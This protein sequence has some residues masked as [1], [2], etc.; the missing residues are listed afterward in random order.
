MKIIARIRGG[1]GNQLFCYA[2]AR[3]LAVLNNAELVID[4]VT[5]FV[6]DQLY[7]RNYMLNR[8]QISAR[9]ATPSERMEPF[10]RYRRGVAKW[11]ARRV[12]FEQRRYIEQESLDFDERLLRIS[13]KGTIY[14]DGLWENESYFKDAEQI[15]REDL[16]VI[17]PTDDMNK[18]IAAEIHEKSAVAIHV[19]WFSAP[20]SS[21]SHHIST[22]Y[23]RD[24]LNL[25]ENTVGKPHYFLFSDNLDAARTMLSLPE[26][27]VTFMS[28]NRGSDNAYADLWLMTQCKHIIIANSTFSWWGAW[29]NKNS[30]K[31][32]VAPCKRRITENNLSCAPPPASW[33]QV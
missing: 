9:K 7:R 32:V 13:V 21:V 25:I 23:Y 29:L 20:G 1:L 6:R 27:R 22:D 30:L 31:V 14:L 26:G 10:E 17:P 12:P 24:A 11:L 5:G 15:I 3:R 18:R 19:R 33:I 16:Q 28:H 2:A 4:G 8:F